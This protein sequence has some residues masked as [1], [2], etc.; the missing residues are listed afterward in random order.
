MLWRGVVQ[1][2]GEAIH[3][4]GWIRRQGCSGGFVVLAHLL[5]V[6]GGFGEAALLGGVGGGFGEGGGAFFASAGGVEF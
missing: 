4:G 2:A 6:E 5:G 3:F 1:G